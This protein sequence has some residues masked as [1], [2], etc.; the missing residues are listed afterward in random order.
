M[1]KKSCEPVN[2]WMRLGVVGKFGDVVWPA[3]EALIASLP[4][5]AYIALHEAG[6]ARGGKG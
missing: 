2:G 5:D 1:T 6:R 3:V 4:V